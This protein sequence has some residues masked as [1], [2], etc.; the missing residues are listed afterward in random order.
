[1]TRQ[2]LD[3]TQLKQRFYPEANISGLSHIDGTVRFFKHCP[4]SALP[5]LD[6]FIRKC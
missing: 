3:D 1:M 4:D 5:V 6:V 2:I